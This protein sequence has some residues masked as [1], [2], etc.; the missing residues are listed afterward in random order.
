MKNRAQEL[1]KTL[2]LE[3]NSVRNSTQIRKEIGHAE[4]TYK[5]NLSAEK[6]RLDRHEAERLALCSIKTR[7]ETLFQGQNSPKKLCEIPILD[8]WIEVTIEDGK[9]ITTLH[10]PNEQLLKEGNAMQPPPEMVYRRFYFSNGVPEEYAWTTRNDE[11]RKYG[12][13]AIQRMTV[14]AWLALIQKEN[15]PTEPRA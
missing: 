8:Q 5:I 14:D 4:E 1:E 12:G 15:N 3:T 13:M 2:R 6:A 7:S 9:T 10:P 11:I